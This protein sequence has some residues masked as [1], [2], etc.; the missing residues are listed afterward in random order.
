M[1]VGVGIKVS[2]ETPHLQ[3]TENLGIYTNTYLCRKSAAEKRV[4][5]R[6]ISLSDQ[7]DKTLEVQAPSFHFVPN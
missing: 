1:G 4:G 6:T 2:V 7:M 5:K 3:G